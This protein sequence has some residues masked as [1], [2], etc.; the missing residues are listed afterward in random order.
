MRLL[1]EVYKAD[2]GG[3]LP[4]ILSYYHSSTAEI[5]DIILLD[6]VPVIDGVGYIQ[7]FQSLRFLH[8]ENVLMVIV[9]S[10][11][12]QTELRLAARLGVNTFS[13]NPLISK[14]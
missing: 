3:R 5:P 12:S 8:K 14:A 2:N 1:K 10:S 9:T 7:A 6:H 4:E 11:T 13:E